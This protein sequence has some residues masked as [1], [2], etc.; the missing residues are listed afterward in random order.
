MID[1]LRQRSRPYLF[2]NSVAPAIVAASI[3]V[4][5]LLQESGDLRAR[6]WENAAH[7]RTRMTEAG[8]TM[9]VPITP[10]SPS[11]WVMPKWRRSLLSAH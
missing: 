2:S 11:C 1:W 7:F 6:L 3:R 5:D 9:A 8:F 4:L 10:S